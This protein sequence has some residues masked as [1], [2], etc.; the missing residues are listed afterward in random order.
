MPQTYVQDAWARDVTEFDG[1]QN[2]SS[3]LQ[4]ASKMTA[5]GLATAKGYTPQ[6]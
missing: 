3:F 5:N 4:R 1:L 2:R 6:P